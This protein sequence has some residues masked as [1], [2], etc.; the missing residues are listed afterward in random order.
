MKYDN[1]NIYRLKS[2]NV[3][4]SDAELE[5]FNQKYKED[6]SHFVLLYPDGTIHSVDGQTWQ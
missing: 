3:I 5:Q 1:L 2:A 6:N 4:I